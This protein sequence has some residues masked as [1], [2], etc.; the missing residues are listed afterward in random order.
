MTN[1][2]STRDLILDAFET[3]VIDSGERSATLEQVAT[4]AGVSKGGLLYHFASRNDLVAGEIQRLSTLAEAEVVE[5]LAAPDGMVSRFIRLSVAENTP[6]DRA[7]T[8]ISRLA[9]SGRHPD[10][11]VALEK[12]EGTWLRML[13]DALGDAVVARMVLL[14][15]DGLYYRSAMFPTDHAVSPNTDELLVAVDQ[16]LIA[17]SR[18]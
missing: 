18:Q 13:T 2:R 4:K 5:L 7:F 3:I 17:R 9:Q 1:A 16:L 12:I 10:I 15:T 8:M 6:L 14:M 11:F